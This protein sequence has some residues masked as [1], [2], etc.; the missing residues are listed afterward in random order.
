MGTLI[1]ELLNLSRLTR[2]EVRRQ[3]V[4]LAEATAAIVADLERHHPDRE[5]RVCVSPN[6]TADADPE[7]VHIALANL[8]DNAWKYTGRTARP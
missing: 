7:L 8:L 4:D 3:Q 6:L 5:V 2:V 1:D